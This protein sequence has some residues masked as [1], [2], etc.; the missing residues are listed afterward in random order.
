[1]IRLSEPGE[2]AINLIPLRQGVELEDFAR[3]SAEVDQP[4]L[5][6]QDVVLGFDAYAVT[7]R[8]E[9]APSVDIVEVM[10]VRSWSEWVEVRDNA[11]AIKPVGAGFEQRVDPST[12]RTLFGNR[13]APR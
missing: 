1:M 13:I 9:G 3:F 6:A 5:L 12:V 7:R 11:A 2:Y 10:H 8:D 4:T